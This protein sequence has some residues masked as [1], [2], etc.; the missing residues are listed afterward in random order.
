MCV[1]ACLRRSFVLYATISVTYAF[2]K[3]TLFRG[4]EVPTPA[5][6]LVPGFVAGLDIVTA[7]DA[8]ER[9]KLC[10]AQEEAAKCNAV[11]GVV[12]SLVSFLHSFL[13]STWLA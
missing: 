13:P 2:T 4:R 1:R 11:A 5:S 6:H 8:M 3:A 7:M 10:A 9:S 12:P